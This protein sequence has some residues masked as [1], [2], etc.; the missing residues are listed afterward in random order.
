MVACSSRSQTAEG[1]EGGADTRGRLPAAEIQRT[2]RENYG[3]FRACYEAGLKRDPSLTG[4]VVTEFVIDRKGGVSSVKLRE[5]TLPDPVA[6][7]CIVEHF[8]ELRFP[9]PD[10]GIVTVVYPIQFAPG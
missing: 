3:T 8:R 1:P 4:R 9:A 5:S 10:G 6:T 2:V 7:D